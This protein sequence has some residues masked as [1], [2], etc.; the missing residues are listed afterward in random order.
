MGNATPPS[1]TVLKEM[2]DKHL[3]LDDG[4]WGVVSSRADVGR[5]NQREADVMRDVARGKPLVA[6]V[7]RRRQM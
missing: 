7:T 3:E 2:R 5:C 1:G 4:E 6:D